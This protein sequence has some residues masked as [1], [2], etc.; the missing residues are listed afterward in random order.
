MKSLV[1]PWDNVVFTDFYPGEPND[2]DCVIVPPEKDA[3]H[4][5]YDAPCAIINRA[6]CEL[7]GA[8]HC[9]CSI[10][11]RSKYVDCSH[12]YLLIM[13]F[14][15]GAFCKQVLP[16]CQQNTDLLGGRFDLRGCWW[17]TV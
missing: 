6:I 4:R 2:F 14:S 17:Q 1:N 11:G 15:L 8:Q 7:P 3:K 9:S 16:I 10:G 13:S 5:W 12:Q